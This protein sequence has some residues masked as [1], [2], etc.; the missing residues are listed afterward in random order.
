VQPT[1]LFALRLASTVEQIRRGEGKFMQIK[2]KRVLRANSLSGIF[3]RN[4]TKVEIKAM[5]NSL[6][7]SSLEC[8]NQA[9]GL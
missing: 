7:L 9:F 8:F 6:L 2:Q 4:A 1:V 3:M 5:A